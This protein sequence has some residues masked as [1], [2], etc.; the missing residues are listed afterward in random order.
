M[1]LDQL[2]SKILEQSRGRNRYLAGIAGPPGAGKSTLAALLLERL[3]SQ[4]A[5]A[6]IVP[7]DGFHLDNAELDR[8]GLRSRKGAPNTFDALGFVEL[9]KD[10]RSCTKAVSLP[11]FDRQQDRVLEDHDN[12]SVDQ[13]ILL[14]EGN[15]LLLKTAPWNQLKPFFDLSVFI[16]PGEEELKKRLIQRW[17]DNNHT[18]AQAVERAHSNDIPNAKFVLKHS[19]NADILLDTPT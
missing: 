11:G 6:K 7:M 2:T 1:N 14:V 4:G 16:N 15:Y 19:D 10:L 17:L 18:H 8:L 5:A 12:I 3:I 9:V 13:Q